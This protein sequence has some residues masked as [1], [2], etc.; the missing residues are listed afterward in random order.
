MMLKEIFV[1]GNTKK[2]IRA[3]ELITKSIHTEFYYYYNYIV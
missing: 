3:L 1:F 2:T